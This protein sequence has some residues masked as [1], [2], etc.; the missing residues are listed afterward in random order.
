M[1]G[2]VEQRLEEKRVFNFTEGKRCVDKQLSTR[3]W[4]GVTSDGGDLR[5]GTQES[6]RDLST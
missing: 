2:I 5:A 4:G 1:V 3:C 6:P